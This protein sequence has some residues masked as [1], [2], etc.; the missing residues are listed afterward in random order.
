[1]RKLAVILFNLG[2]PDDEQ[3]V[4]PFL[5]NLF[6]DPAILRVREPIRSWLAEFISKRREKTA[7]SIYAR[8]GGKSP[9]LEN[10]LAQAR[11]LEKRLN[12]QDWARC[13]VAMR[14]WHPFADETIAEVRRFVP[15]ELVLL[16]LYPQF[17]TTTTASSFQSWKDAAEQDGLAIPTCSVPSYPTE[18]GFIASMATAADE[19]LKKA[20]RFGTPRLLLSAHGLPERIVRDGD[21]YAQQC[22]ET[23]QAVA[24]ALNRPHLDWTLCYQSRVG[25]MKWIGPPTDQEIRRAGKERKPVVV[26]PVSFVAE[27]SETLVD[28][29]MKYRDLAGKSGVPYFGYAGAVG[30]APAF[31]EGLAAL[32][33]RALERNGKSPHC[34]AGAENFL[35]PDAE[36][37]QRDTINRAALA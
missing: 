26:S 28:I 20:E 15:D 6:S 35:S 37:A 8:M 24:R 23:A 25:P 31:I 12:Q 10:T 36:R 32:V 16:P 9:L 7:L 22:A 11:E 13:F 30:L 33:Y 29:D 19:A 3:A 5:Y 1:M 14:Y 17:S 34:Q 2:G 21:P 4:R 27:C 18:P